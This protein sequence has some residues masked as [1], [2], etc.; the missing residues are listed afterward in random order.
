M[1]YILNFENYLTKK[2]QRKKN[3][4]EYIN[5]NGFDDRYYVCSIC[6]SYKLKPIS[7]GGFSSPTWECQDCGNINYS[8]TWMSPEEYEEF[9]EEK[10][11]K[12]QTKKFNL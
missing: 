3:Y 11:I 4:N 8:P 10:E 12:K 7:Q 2:Y 5:D 6:D 1:L 9:L